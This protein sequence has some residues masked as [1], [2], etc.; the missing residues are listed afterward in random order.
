MASS[1]P[2]S[3]VRDSATRESADRVAGS[4]IGG[5]SNEG[6]QSTRE[7]AVV[8]YNHIAG[9]LVAVGGRHNHLHR[10][11]GG[12]AGSEDAKIDRRVLVCHDLQRRRALDSRFR[13]SDS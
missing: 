1:I 7:A 2:G 12:C 8:E 11:R 4:V 9:S 10:G 5:E 6:G 13:I 3:D